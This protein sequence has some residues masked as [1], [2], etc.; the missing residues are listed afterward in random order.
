MVDYAALLSW[1]MVVF[2]SSFDCV[3][4]GGGV[5]LSYYAVIVAR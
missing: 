5:V 4:L 2:S 3:I 1:V